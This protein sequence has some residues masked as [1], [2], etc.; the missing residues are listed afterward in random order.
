MT[1]HNELI[2]TVIGIPPPGWSLGHVTINGRN[3][4]RMPIEAMRHGHFAVHEVERMAGR[5]WRLTHA[6][7]GLQIWTFPTLEQAIE[8]AERIEGFT[9]WGAFD[10]M[11]PAGTDLYPRVREV[12]DHI[13]PRDDGDS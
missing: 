10:K 1:L 9:D 7:S 2:E 8:L 5:G 11:L 4:Q 13:A 12:V 3:G 6:P